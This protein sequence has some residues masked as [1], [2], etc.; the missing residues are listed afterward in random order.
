MSNPNFDHDPIYINLGTNTGINST[1]LQNITASPAVM[2]FSNQDPVIVDASQ[3][4]MSLNRA[5]IST[6]SIPIFI[7]PIKNG[8]TQS[9]INLSPFIIRF[10]YF[11]NNVI[12]YTYTDN[13]LYI[14]S[15]DIGHLP[16]APSDNGGYQ[17]L[18]NN[19][20]SEYYYIYSI[21]WMLYIF[22]DNIKRIFSD[23][24]FNLAT[25]TGV[26]I[27]N[28]SFPFYTFD[29][30]TRLFSLNFEK[31]YFDQ[32]LVNRVELRQDLPSADL[33]G[34]PY[35]T[36]LTDPLTPCLMM[37]R[38]L[39]NNEYQYNSNDYYRMTASQSSL[40]IWVCA[41]RLVF[42]CEGIPLRKLEIE[43][44]VN[45]IPFTASNPSSSAQIARPQ[46]NIFFDLNIDADQFAVNSNVVNYTVSSIAQSRLVSLGSGQIIQNF[47][48]NIYWCDNFGNYH[49][50]NS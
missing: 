18:S 39:Y 46:L 15:N 42:T 17:D 25:N 34:C 11:Q 3:Y 10:T 41:K 35:S 43:N 6:A 36:Y 9:D 8:I 1:A 45:Q 37:A 4:Y 20:A 2:N 38:D 33:F 7:F 27:P 24:V 14:P 49:A 44:I 22:N 48:I 30:N 12:L 31:Q 16:S 40:N 29:Y 19:Y 5:N 28:T 32:D 21:S 47:K 23:F 13:V 50:L 26:N